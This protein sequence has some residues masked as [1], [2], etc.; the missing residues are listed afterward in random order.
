MDYYS[1]INPGLWGTALTYSFLFSLLYLVVAIFAYAFTALCLQ[2]M[3][4]KKNIPNS[5]FAWIPILNIYLMCQIAQK[6]AWWII[7]CFIPF[8]STVITILLLVGIAKAFG[9][10][11]WF[12]VLMILPIVNLFAWG[13]LAFSKTGDKASEVKEQTSTEIS[14]DKSQISVQ[15]SPEPRKSKTWVILAIVLIILG[16]LIGGGIWGYFKVKGLIED[17]SSVTNEAVEKEETPIPEEEKEEGINPVRPDKS[18]VTVSASS[19]SR[20]TTGT[21][22]DYS[23]S[24]VLD[25]DFSTSWTE[26]VKDEGKDEWILLEFPSKAKINT[27]GIVPGYARDTDIY[28][29]NNRLKSFEL[30]FSDGTKINKELPDKYG[31]HFIEFSTIETTFLKLTIKNIYSGSKYNDTCIAEIDIWSDYVLNKDAQAA[32]NYYKKYKGVYALKPQEKYIIDAFMTNDITETLAPDVKLYSY[33][34]DMDTFIAS[35]RL[36][37]DTPQGKTFTA[38]WYQGNK[39]FYTD[40]ITSYAPTYTGDKMYIASVV[41]VNTLLGEDGLWPTGDYKVVWYENGGLSRSVKFKVA[42]Q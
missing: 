21:G 17:P 32:L 40:K 26:D 10:S 15:P 14:K 37:L 33:A 22:F 9:K 28:V 13:Y 25:Q 29:E 42:A 7:L 1:F 19:V 36:R 12:A 6:P 20:D 24:Q 35:A 5:W 39:L 16:I 41:T 38:K 31:M 2:L 8:V 4:K 30:E 34:A 27:L 11:G 3:A 23:P 18:E